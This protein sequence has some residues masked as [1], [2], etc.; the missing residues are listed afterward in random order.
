MLPLELTHYLLFTVYHY[1]ILSPLPSSPPALLVLPQDVR[2]NVMLL[3]SFLESVMVQHV[4]T[5]RRHTDVAMLPC[6]GDA[7]RAADDLA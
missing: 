1:T 3:Q 5:Q 6:V 2:H 4:P 7:R